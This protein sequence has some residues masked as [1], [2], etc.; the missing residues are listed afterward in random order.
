MCDLKNMRWSLL[1][2]S[3]IETHFRVVCR[4]TLSKVNLPSVSRSDPDLRKFPNNPL[5]LGTVMVLGIQEK[6]CEP[7]EY[8]GITREITRFW[9]RKFGKFDEESL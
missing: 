4:R 8:V 2:N 5:T 7:C 6:D 9:I 3:S 1:K